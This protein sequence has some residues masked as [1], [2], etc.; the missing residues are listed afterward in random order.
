MNL[1]WLVVGWGEGGGRLGTCNQDRKYCTSES[2][3]M[4]MK[5]L[6]FGSICQVVCGR[7]AHKDTMSDDKPCCQCQGCDKC[8]PD[9]WS[10][11]PCTQW[12]SRYKLSGYRHVTNGVPLCTPCLEQRY[13]SNQSPV[14]GKGN[15]QTFGFGKA[16][17]GAKGK[18][19]GSNDGVLHGDGWLEHVGPPGFNAHVGKGF[20]D[21]GPPGFVD[22]GN[23]GAASS[24]GGGNTAETMEV[25][26]QIMLVVS[27]QEGEI[28]EI[29][30]ALANQAS[31]LMSIQ[32]S[33][34]QLTNATPTQNNSCSSSGAG[35]W[36]KEQP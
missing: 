13:R 10:W 16:G 33:L 21:N 8:T 35:S 34:A 24:N 1:G 3:T 20:N 7:C 11:T 2:K 26:T 6:V 18:E 31:I 5:F 25:L 17:K 9:D 28:Q 30:E 4:C 12:S 32:S 36:E 23:N 15:Q 22:N 14:Y 19:K 27:R 29:K